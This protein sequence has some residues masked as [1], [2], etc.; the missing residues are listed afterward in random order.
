MEEL[1][2]V[3]GDD[4]D[5]EYYKLYVKHVKTNQ[6][7]DYSERELKFFEIVIRILEE[8]GKKG[9]WRLLKILDVLEEIEIKANDTR[10]K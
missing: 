5:E 10:N 8:H 9:V 6:D 3:W 2:E 4:K 7:E 1:E